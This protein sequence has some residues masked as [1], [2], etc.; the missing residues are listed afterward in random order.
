[1]DENLRNEDFPLPLS[2]SLFQTISEIREKCSLRA[3]LFGAI[4]VI[5]EKFVDPRNDTARN[6]AKSSSSM[7]RAQIHAM[8]PRARPFR[9]RRNKESAKP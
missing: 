3:F 6:F 9:S 2:F 7:M 4:L 8:N 1:M 5:A